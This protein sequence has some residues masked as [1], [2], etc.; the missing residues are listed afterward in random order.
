MKE[1]Y[2]LGKAKNEGYFIGGV[3]KADGSVDSRKYI[4]ED[5]CD[6]T[7]T[8]IG[9]PVVPE[10]LGQERFDVSEVG[11]DS[12]LLKILARAAGSACESLKNIC[13]RHNGKPNLP[14]RMNAFDVIVGST[15]ISLPNCHP[16][17]VERFDY[18]LVYF[19]IPVSKRK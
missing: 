5:L 11:S 17:I 4:E 15:A 10:Y 7:T 16:D 8:F 14:Q 6:G 18:T 13:G 9:S 19:N 1:L 2:R 12:H 3:L